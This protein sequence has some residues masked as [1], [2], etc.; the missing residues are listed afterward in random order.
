MILNLSKLLKLFGL[1]ELL[2]KKKIDLV[3]DIV[4][5][6]SNL[7]YS[8]AVYGSYE[9]NCK[10]HIEVMKNLANIKYMGS[11]DDFSKIAD[12]GYDI[13][14]YTSNWDGLPNVLLEAM[15]SGLIV[16]APAVGGIGELIKHEENGFLIADNNDA[17]AYVDI[18]SKILNQVY[19]L[20]EIR[21]NS[22]SKITV[23]HS[24]E[25]FRKNLCEAKNYLTN[26]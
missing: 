23:Q 10:E 5:Q 18:L 14:L 16:I 17:S 24:L 4:R 8:F 2:W 20:N 6:C 26:I 19:D 1:Q 9:D 21:Q 11:Y 3:L 22:I 12:N 15:A 25:Q 13:F 7:P